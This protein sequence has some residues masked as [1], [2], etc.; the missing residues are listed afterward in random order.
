MSRER[1]DIRAQPKKRLSDKPAYSQTIERLS[2]DQRTKERS[3][4]NSRRQS[5]FRSFVQDDQPDTVSSTEPLV[6]DERQDEAS[7]NSMTAVTDQHQSN[8]RDYSL[9]DDRLAVSQDDTRGEAV[10][11]LPSTVPKQHQET[12]RRFSQSDTM[13]V[14]SQEDTRRETVEDQPSDAIKQ[15]K[16]DHH[17]LT[18]AGA[19][20]IG[21]PEQKADPALSDQSLSPQEEAKAG[22]DTQNK[23]SHYYQR[24][25][26]SARAEENNTRPSKLNF[27]DDELPDQ[28][29]A[30]RMLEKAQARAERLEGRLHKAENRLPSRRRPRINV[31][32]DPA[33]GKSKKRLK[34][35]KEIK[36]QSQ[37]LNGPTALRPVK[38]AANLA[39]GVIHNQIYRNE[40]ENVG[41]QA[42]HRTEIAGE[43]GLRY[44]NRARKLAPYNKVRRLQN[45]TVNAQA[46]AAYQKA[47]SDDPSLKK[48]TLSKLAYKRKLKRKYAKAAH[49]AQKAGKRTK[50]VAVATERI[51]NK[52]ILFVK[53]H[54]IAFLLISLLLFLIIF[55][56][57]AFSSCTS[58]GAGAG[59]L[60][61]ASTYQ[62][63]EYTV[64]QAELTYTEWETDL[65]MQIND[66]ENSHPGYDEYRYRIDAIEHDPYVLMGYLT[67]VYGEFTYSQAVSA[68]SDLFDSQ[69]TLTLT[70]EIQHRRRKDLLVDPST[71]QQ[72]PTEIE[73]E[74]RILNVRLTLTPL[75]H[76][77][78]ARMDD[79]QKMICEALMTTKGGCQF[80]DNVF[81]DTNWLRYVSSEFGYRVHPVTKA[82]DY[83]TGADIAMACG[84]P[85]RAGHDGTVTFADE[86][87]DYGL[88]VELEGQMSDGRSLVT[89]YAHCSQIYVAEGQ[90][91]R[92]GDVIGAVGDSGSSTGTHLHLE[93]IVDGDYLD[94]LFFVDTGDSTEQRLP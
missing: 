90:T 87:G 77:V 13:S 33:T 43:A 53:N 52:A 28:D 19:A 56:T 11:S 20:S 32:A 6:L 93:V 26:E 68:M 74:F 80:V 65:R 47:L 37:A 91:V 22:R 64:T 15:Q 63:D 46:K 83:H 84:T 88:Y 86:Y 18:A 78:S 51:A 62:A 30:N 12:A 66:I 21:M 8:D 9:S 85:I 48:K 69:F 50:D 14:A 35:E 40:Q 31:S 75:E 5:Y 24:F 92:A 70:E 27:A 1:E 23:K 60:I 41:V 76:I 49:D 81:G 4:A 34:F 82:K 57:S 54:P 38:A 61:A 94:P 3:G 44:A 72:L 59:G 29:A 17:I 79:E 36:S 7:G 16:N 2:S 58:I 42:A 71:H 45:K 39:G 89:R 55:I 67:A 25:R 73:Y 10:D